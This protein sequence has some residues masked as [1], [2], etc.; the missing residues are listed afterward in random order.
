LSLGVI[1]YTVAKV[2]AGKFREV[3]VLLWILTL[4]FVLRYIYMAAE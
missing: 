1:S 4:V 3:S 2:A